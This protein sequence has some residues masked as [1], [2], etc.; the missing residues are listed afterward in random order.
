[1]AGEGTAHVAPPRSDTAWVAALVA[2]DPTGLGGV[3]L[4]A[5]AGGARDAW[6]AHLIASLPHASPVRRIPLHVDDDRLLGGLDLA[7]TLQ[8]GRVVADRGL[9]ADADG[10]LVVLAMAE[11]LAAGTAA[12]IATVLD[13]GE[14]VVE[15]AGSAGRVP[16]RFGVVALDEGIG[17]DEAVPTR[18][19]ERLAF[20]LELAPREV[21]AAE[22]P[23]RDAIAAARL[24]LPA[25]VVGDAVVD[26]VCAAALALG[27]MSIRAP[28]LALRAA[29]GVAALEGRTSVTADDAALAARLVLAH[30]ATRLP[31]EAAPE[32]PAEASPSEPPVEPE[33]PDPPDE[34]PRP[35]AASRE[36]AEDA[37]DDAAQA[38]PDQPLPDPAEAEPPAP[39]GDEASATPRA[40]A[41]VDAEQVLAAA[42]AALPPHLLDA[43]QRLPVGATRQA[44]VGRSG[45]LLHG[46]SHGR[47]VG[48]RRAVPR[49]G[50][51]LALLETLRAAAP[52]QRLRREAA[53]AEGLRRHEP[54]LSHAARATQP[55]SLPVEPHAGARPTDAEPLLRRGAAAGLPAA[56]PSSGAVAS[57]RPTLH[58]RRE[59]FHV[60][61][62]ALRRETTT[63]FVVDASGS[64]ALHR[65][66]EAKGA[67]E[68]LLADCYVRRDSV[69][70]I[71]FRGSGAELLL[72]PTRSLARAKRGLAGL[73]G[74]GATPLAA[75][76]DAAASLVDA[77][78][79]RG[80]TPFVVL[81]TDGRGNVGRDGTPGRAAALRDALAAGERLRATGA[82]TLLLDTSP[83]PQ[84]A[85][86]RI[87]AALGGR[88]LPLPHAGAHDV[89]AAIRSASPQR[90]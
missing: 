62:H 38:S 49:G 53:D 34:A 75:G 54:P 88:Y 40:A 69:A 39:T 10:G 56:G 48:V 30:R 7:G 44:T 46:A 52:W 24:A 14:L 70:L 67:V 33:A 16:A 32:E 22:P 41:P 60:H 84:D 65:L 3:V 20:R 50:A 13:T 55:G 89:S 8:A 19:A 51:R 43:L 2:L 76:L 83:R 4:R 79:R 42:V 64:S 58:I 25:V 82:A 36:P 57:P 27:A 86:V 87:A 9:L 61:R 35:D 47:P 72:P 45:A 81:L 21:A 23:S 1:M 15:R 78:R 12:R 68:L 18:L 29:R 85:A 80:V 90:R 17:E 6:L 11:R 59:D 66:A 73:P 74:G 26:A 28:L 63:V 5:A 37:P 77:L 71:A 31:T